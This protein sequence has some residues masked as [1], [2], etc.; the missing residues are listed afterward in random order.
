[1]RKV[2]DTYQ[3]QGKEEGYLVFRRSV[4]DTP[5]MTGRDFSLWKMNVI[6]GVHVRDLLADDIYT[7]VHDKYFNPTGKAA[8]CTYCGLLLI[9]TGKSWVCEIDSCPSREQVHM[10][11]VLHR[12]DGGLHHVIRPIREFVVAPARINDY[13]RASGYVPSPDREL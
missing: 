1:M 9:P 8:T 13:A 12:D 6:G 3:E 7:A 4:I 10:G 11:S 5:V 2:F